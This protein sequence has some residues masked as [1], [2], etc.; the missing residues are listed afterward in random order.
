MGL[1]NGI[2]VCR[3]DNLPFGIRHLDYD[4]WRKEHH[5]DIEI[6]YWRKCWGIRRTILDILG[7]SSED[8]SEFEM[9]GCEVLAVIRALKTINKK[10]W[11]ERAGD[12]WTWEEY[13]NTHR[14]NIRRLK[15]LARIMRRHPDLEVYF[16]DSY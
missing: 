13:K 1:D 4:G 7:V 10:N 8:D 6:A 11:E 14:W 15:R 9:N 12:Y 2:M 3:K 5:L 16:Y